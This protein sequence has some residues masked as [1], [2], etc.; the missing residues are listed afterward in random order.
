MTAV[1]AKKVNGEQCESTP[2]PTKTSLTTSTIN[3]RPKLMT[4]GHFTTYMQ[5]RTDCNTQTYMLQDGGQDATSDLGSSG[6]GYSTEAS[7]VCQRKR[8][9]SPSCQMRH[10]PRQQRRSRP[11]SI[12]LENQSGALSVLQWPGQV[13]RKIKSLWSLDGEGAATAPPATDTAKNDLYLRLGLLLGDRGRMAHHSPPSQSSSQES[14]ASVSSLT[15]TETNTGSA[16]TSPLSTLTGSSDAGN[17][18]GVGLS[19]CSSHDPSFDSMTSL[20]SS[21]TGHSGS[22]S[23]FSTLPRRHSVTTSAPGQVEELFLFDKRKCPLRRSARAGTVKGPIDPRVRFAPYRLPQIN[24]KPQFFEVP[25]QEKEPI[26]IGRNWMFREI[27]Q[28]LSKQSTYQGIIIAGGVGTGKTTAILQLVDH[29]CFGRK[30]EAIY[31]EI[32]SGRDSAMGS[33]ASLINGSHLSLV[34]DTVR[35]LGAQVVAYHFCQADNNV[36]CFV[37]D[38]VHSLAAQLCQAPQLAA[39]RALLGT[40]PQLQAA[41][42][43]KECISNP[44]TALVHGILEPLHK[45]KCLGKILSSTCIIVIDSLNEAE[46]HRPDYGDTITSFLAKHLENFPPWLKLIVTIRTSLQDM[47]N[48]LPFHR[49]SLD[50]NNVSID[51]VQK[52]L[53]DYINLR[54]HTSP[55]IRNNIA[56]NGKEGTSQNRFINH[57]VQLSRGNFLYVR[58]TLDL[59]ERGHLVIKSS[60]FKVLPVTLSEVYMLHFNLKFPSLRSFE[61]ILMI[62]NVCLATLYPMTLLEIYHS[63]NAGLT[64]R[65]LLWKDFVSRMDVLTGFLTKRQDGSFMFFHPSFREWLLRREENESIKYLCDPRSGHANIAFRMSRLEGPL[66]A[67]KT[68]ELAHHILKA[69]IYK[70]INFQVNFTARDMQALWVS[71]GSADVSS[72]LCSFRNLYSPNVKASRLL[73]LSG[74][75]PNCETTV[76]GGSPIMCVA[77]HEGFADMVSMLLEFGADVSHTNKEYQSALCVAAARGH[78]EIIRML[79]AHGAEMNYVDPSGQC[80]LTYAACGGHVGVLSFLLQNDWSKVDDAHISLSEAAQ[81]ALVGAAGRGYTEV[82]EYL[83]KLP[84]VG[85]DLSDTLYG[86]TALTA[87][88]SHGYKDTCLLLLQKGASVMVSGHLSSIPPI[89]CAVRYGHWEV[90]DLL[91]LYHAD[92]DQTDAFGKTPLMV[93]AAE[94]HL[95][96]LE[97]LL[98]KGASISK[99]DKEGLTSLC[100]ACIKGQ[101]YATQCLLE[102]GA[103]INHTDRTGRTPLDMAAARGEPAVVQLLLDRGALVEH[104]DHSGMRPLDRAISCTNT[105]AIVCFLR[106]GAKLGP[107]TWAMAAGKP[108]V[109]LILLNKLMEDGAVLYRKNRLVEAAHRYQYALKKFPTEEMGEDISTFQQLKIQLLLSLARCK[110]KMNEHE[111][112]IELTNQVL[113]I[114]PNCF[115][116]FYSRARAR[117]DLKQLHLALDDLEEAMKLAPQNRE[118]RRI[119]LRIRDEIGLQ[120][121]DC[122]SMLSL[123]PL[124]GSMEGL[125]GRQQEDMAA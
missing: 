10:L 1:V 81:Q 3:N 117:R 12:S 64:Q 88:C 94:G 26:F 106:K 18:S 103:N 91:L 52:D 87:A 61:K 125:D 53:H 95:G 31:Q 14:Y 29:S 110:R 28:E 83:L 35:T 22:G 42:S 92:V 90:V 82:C 73:L 13:L 24:L 121:A 43:L 79:Y 33:R 67:D 85:I 25:Q 107:A 63:V 20:M 98:N 57:L 113:E 102:H 65:V 16:N 30:D 36:T 104:V 27:E 40:D 66:D 93:A 97:L 45:L 101:L 7:P 50:M 105:Q 49:I 62:L 122:N 70:N 109:V 99:T 56:S 119:L 68:G 5:A 32:C 108:E 38:F 8:Y 120:E 114:S 2:Y 115:E 60:S 84:V 112:A 100:W 72:A 37:P 76:L 69:H 9:Q 59:I 80:A 118:I 116:A 6:A 19:L 111:A 96:V 44:S 48:H 11:N 74:A 86:E 77:A 124:S 123:V 54:I 75:N 15:S 34:P 41:L 47:A 51:T 78:T 23:P 4:N 46:Y 58:L 71:L 17:F 55:T 21:S 89:I 39:F